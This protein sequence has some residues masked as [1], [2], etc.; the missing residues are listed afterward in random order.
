MSR[1]GPWCACVTWRSTKARSRSTCDARWP[2][3]S[4]SP[5]RPRAIR[6][7]D[8]VAQSALE[9]DLHVERQ[10][11]VNSMSG[12]EKAVEAVVFV[13]LRKPPRA[14]AV[15][16]CLGQGEFQREVSRK[17]EARSGLVRS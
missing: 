5:A 14:L 11:G 12:D 3:K 2:A 1:P 4:A 6:A 8:G 9:V 16:S 13:A 15:F 7:I 17:C 10:H